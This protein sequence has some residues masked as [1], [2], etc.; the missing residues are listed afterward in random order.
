M[1]FIYFVLI[2]G[3]TIFIHE[4]GHFIFA[5]RAKVYCHEFSLGMGP[6]IWS[7]RRKNDETLYSLRLFPIG[8]FV[9]MAGEE[10]E[11]DK[12]VPRDRQ[13]F[14]KKWSQKFMTIIA[15][16]M[17]NFIFAVIIFFFLALFNGSPSTK[18]I[19]SVVD[20]G[21]PAYSA[22]LESGDI[23]K[24]VN[25]KKVTSI[26]R[27]MLELH[28]VKN[29]E[30]TL[31]IKRDEIIKEIKITAVEVTEKDDTKRFVF[32]FGLESKIEK[33]FLV[34]LQYAFMKTGYLIEQ[35]FWI[36]T[37]LITGSIGL[38]NLSG[39]IGIYNIVGETARSGIANLFYLLAY[40][41]INVG[42][43]NL[44]PIPAFDGGRILFL[45]LEKIK[46][47]PIDPKVENSI[48]SVGFFLLMLLMLLI[49]Y[50]DIIRIFVG[51]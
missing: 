25:G 37:Y 20:K 41:S 32:G 51:G 35:M 11:E 8:G 16:I 10:L 49:T 40:I 24:R 21:L 3:I 1:T 45:L 15:G 7:F 6:K 22:G 38:N 43:I 42:F 18:P 28:V 31:E 12:D 34:S 47:R 26:D 14:A 17:F 29:D 13:L 30:I 2:L 9:Q 50:N 23:I 4:L 33:G 5:K 19:V 44:L 36:V 46:G 39:P 27:L 48:H